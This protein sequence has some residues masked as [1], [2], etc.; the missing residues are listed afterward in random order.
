MTDLTRQIIESKLAM[1]AELADL[2][3]DE[4]IKILEQLRD[5][6]FAIAEAR[7]I[8]NR[9]EKNSLLPKT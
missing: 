9:S 4:K 8:S 7:H 5:R 2:P 1:R 3:I 6:S